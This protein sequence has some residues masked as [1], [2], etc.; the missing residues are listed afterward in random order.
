M[1]LRKKS[2]LIALT[3]GDGSLIEQKKFKPQSKRN[4][5]LE[6]Q[7]GYKQLEY[8]K[9]K[10]DL[11]R[12]VTGTLCNIKK[13]IYK[14]KIIN[15]VK[16]EDSYGYKFISGHRYFK[17]LRKW[18]YPNNIKQLQKKYLKYLDLQGI[19]I[20]Y[21]DDGSTYIDKRKFYYKFQGS[22]EFS[23]CTPKEEAE[24]VIKYFKEYWDL[25]FYLHKCKNDQYKIRCYNEEAIKF[26]NMI[27][28]FVPQCMEYKVRIPEE[29]IHEC[30]AS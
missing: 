21:M 16:R 20:W 22:C 26:I 14:N 25:N 29:Y 2:L 13:K 11:C 28:P 27:K 17:V 7:H 6:V 1:E 10:A 19:A 5:V 12:K 24:E 4:V 23:L 15:G 18:L 8:L 9:W 3:L 30:L